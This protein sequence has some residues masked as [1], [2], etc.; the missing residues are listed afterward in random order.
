[1]PVVVGAVARFAI[2]FGSQDKAV[3]A[4][5]ER[6]AE[7]FFGTAVSIDIGRINKVNA[8]ILGGV[9]NGGHGRFLY[10]APELVGAHADDRHAHA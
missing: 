5:F 4:P 1:V 7:R 8:Q 9:Q 2:D 10:L 6:C 3:P